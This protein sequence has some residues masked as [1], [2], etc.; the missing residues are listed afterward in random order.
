MRR[1][2]AAPLFV[3]LLLLAASQAAWGWGTLGHRMVGDIAQRHLAPETSR[4]IARLL[5]GERE[6]SL[7]GIAAWADTLRDRDPARFR[8]TA[9]WHYVNIG[10]AGCRY[11]ATH[12]CPDGRCVVGAIQAQRARLADRRL[13]LAQRREALEYLVHLVGDVHQ[14]LHAGNRGDKGGNRFQVSLRTDR[15]PP[16]FARDRYVDGVLGTN[17]HAVWDYELLATAHLDAHAYASTLEARRWAPLDG[18]RDPAAWAA[19]SCR[20]A[21]APGF[22]PA[23][24]R[25]DERDLDARRPLAEQ[26]IH[27]AGLRLA[28]MLDETLGGSA[29]A[30]ASRAR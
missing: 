19:E 12:D 23:S 29:P 15:A 10:D 14:P 18:A 11:E 17:L 20:I 5:A 27:L 9:R 30:R 1:A 4:E 6:P 3:L 28:R 21:A 16:A 7:A 24:H 8:A 2:P 13:P 22:Y 25:M 26:R